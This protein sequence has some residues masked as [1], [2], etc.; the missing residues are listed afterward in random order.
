MKLFLLHYWPLII[1]AILLIIVSIYT[2]RKKSFREW[3]LFAVVEAEKAL[4]SKTGQIKLR[5]VYDLAMSRFPIFSKL[6]TFTTFEKL[7]NDALDA[8]KKM[9]ADNEQLQSYINKEDE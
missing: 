8:F 7:V 2:L 5:Y 4:G 9:L 6:I 1:I 3:L